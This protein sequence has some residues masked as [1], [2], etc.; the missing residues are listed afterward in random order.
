MNSDIVL[1][2]PLPT[3]LSPLVCKDKYVTC[4]IFET[5][6]LLQM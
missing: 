1:C 4:V 2:A 5:S 6:V 3:V